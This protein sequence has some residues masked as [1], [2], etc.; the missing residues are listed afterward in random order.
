MS[1]CLLFDREFVGSIQQID[2][3][4]SYLFFIFSYQSLSYFNLLKLANKTELVC[5]L[6]NKIFFTS[7]QFL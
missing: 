1:K 4:F 3:L 2:I 6:E 7:P 5:F